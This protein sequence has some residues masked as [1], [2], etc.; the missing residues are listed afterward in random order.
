[1][2]FVAMQKAGDL[3]AVEILERFGIG[4]MPKIAEFMVV[5][6]DYKP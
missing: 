1:M 6:R 2:R 4:V 5:L 3:R